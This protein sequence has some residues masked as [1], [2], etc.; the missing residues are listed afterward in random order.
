MDGFE[1][2]K[3]IRDHEKKLNQHTPIIALTGF[4]NFNFSNIYYIIL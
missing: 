1:C 4:Y 3:L 2:T